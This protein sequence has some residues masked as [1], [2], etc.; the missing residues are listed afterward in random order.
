[1]DASANVLAATC[2]SAS[3]LTAAPIVYLPFSL[4]A[5]DV[6]RPLVGW[7]GKMQAPVMHSTSSLQCSPFAHGDLQDPPQSRPISSPSLSPLKQLTQTPV[8][9]ISLWQSVPLEQLSPS[10]HR[11]QCS[12]PQS[13]PVS[14]PSCT[15]FVHE[16]QTPRGGLLRAIVETSSSSTSTSETWHCAPAM[17]SELRQQRPPSPQAIPTELHNSPPQSTSVSWASLIPLVHSSTAEYARHNPEGV[18]HLPVAQSRS[19][20]HAASIPHLKTHVGPPQSVP[21]SSPSRRPFEHDTQV[22]ATS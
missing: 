1:M 18:S 14:S 19:P 20:S 2:V 11:V 10:G 6:A 22:A 7:L 16:K 3:P 4:H 17:Q 15:P 12:P 5:M 8:M 9:H 13:T 21:V